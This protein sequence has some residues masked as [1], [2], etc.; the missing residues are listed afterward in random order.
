MKE[1]GL[2]YIIRI[3]I[4]PSDKLVY[5][6]IYLSRNFFEREKEEENSIKERIDLRLED[7]K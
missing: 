7:E 2:S 1:V 5:T 6:R 4:Y 3:K